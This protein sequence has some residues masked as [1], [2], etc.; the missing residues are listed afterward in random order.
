M[1]TT[2]EITQSGKIGSHDNT[3][4]GQQIVNEGLSTA[5]AVDIAFKLFRDSYPQFRAEVL[6]DLKQMVIQELNFRMPKQIVE[7]STRIVMSTLQSASIVDEK[8]VRLLYARLLASSLDVATSSDTHPAF[9]RIIDQMDTFDAMLI[10]KIV[11]ISDSIPVANVRFT[12]DTK[13]LTSVLP[14]FYSPYFDCLN[15]PWAV[16]L[17]LENLA[18]LQLI[19]LFEGTVTSYDYEK[20]KT[21]PFI[22]ERFEYAKKHNTERDLK[23]EVSK[24]VIQLT[25]FGKRFSEICITN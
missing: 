1:D 15:N 20:F 11:E 25:D 3:Y 17:S 16:S 10:K 8:D 2:L 22:V 13:Y 24:Y 12:F 23:I 7:P 14:H 4:I 18:R 19:N 21:E 9:P 6:Q 5:D